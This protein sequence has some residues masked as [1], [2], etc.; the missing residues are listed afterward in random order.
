MSLDTLLPKLEDPEHAPPATDLTALSRLEGPDHERFL[1][2]WRS[3]SIQRRRDIID[4][5]AGMAEDNVEMDFNAVFMTGLLDD[6]VQVRAESI[7][8][9]WEYEEDELITV[10]LRLLHDPEAI[11]RAEAALGLGRYLLRAE[12]AGDDGVLV[13]E[14]EVALRAAVH[15]ESELTEVRGRALEAVGVRGDD[16]VRDLIEEAYE[17]GDRRMTI[18]A[19]HAMGRNADLAWLPA[20][21]AEME[22]DDAEMRFE[23]AVAAGGLADEEALP[24]LGELSADADTEVQEAAIAALG[25]IGGPSAQSMLLGIASDKPGER[26]LEAVRD[27]LAEADFVEDPLGFKMYLDQSVAD[28]ADEEDE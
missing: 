26:V 22:S 4:T 20:I 1:G 7:K 3:L 23:A 11:V 21:L 14:V 5:L 12:L 15:D 10:L 27:A 28:D 25:R 19:I 17:T 13:E 24:K 6:D 2:V 9:L 8:A 18:S 16:W